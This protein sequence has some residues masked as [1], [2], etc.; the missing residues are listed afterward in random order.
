M[1]VMAAPLSF[2]SQ[3]LQTRIILDD[4][5]KPDNSPGVNFANKQDLIDNKKNSETQFGNYLLQTLAGGLITVAAPIAIII[6]A[7]SGLMMVTAQGNQ[8]KLD[9]AKQTLTQAIIG[10]VI[11]IFSWVI[12]KAALN[13]VISVNSNQQGTAASTSA[14][15]PGSSSSGGGSAGQVPPPAKPGGPG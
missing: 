7:V 8:G 1:I 14:A 12:V 9:K 4:S 6:I 2:N 11:I 10:L 13:A 15:T 5:L 3:D